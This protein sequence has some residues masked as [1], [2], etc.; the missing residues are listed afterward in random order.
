MMALC[1][2]SA[3]R[4]DA[5]S[6]LLSCVLRSAAL[7]TAFTSETD[8]VAKMTWVSL[9]SLVR[10]ASMKKHCRQPAS[11]PSESNTVLR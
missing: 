7:A 1:C 11:G 3:A 2:C 5:I 8:L 4:R 9:P 10:L 6:R